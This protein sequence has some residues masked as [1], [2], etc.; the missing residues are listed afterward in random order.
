MSTD[1]R[2]PNG[3]QSLF[4]PLTVTGKRKRNFE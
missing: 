2:I 3:Y 4:R 1:L